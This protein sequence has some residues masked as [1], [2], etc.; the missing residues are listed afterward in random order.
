MLQP[1]VNGQ[2]PGY[3]FR[4]YDGKPIELEVT[5]QLST[6]DRIEYLEVVKNGEVAEHVRLDK[7]AAAGGRLPPMMF[8][9]S[10][11]M[12]IRAVTNVEETYRFASTGPYYVEFGD[13]PRISKRSAQFFLEWVYERARSVRKHA[14]PS[15]IDEAIKPYR[16]ARDYWR[17][18]VDAANVE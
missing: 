5:L 11:W 9:E 14:D 7:W 17:S 18:L 6:R 10:G 16:E 4:G 2:L 15:Q 12:L 3:V 13:Q 8:S 1:R